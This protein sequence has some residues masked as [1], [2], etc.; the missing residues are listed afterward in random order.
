MSGGADSPESD[1]SDARALERCLA[2]GGV[3]LFGADTVYG[4]ACDPS[5][6]LPVERLYRLKRRS[7]SKPSA[8]MFFDLSLAL[9]ALPELGER[10]RQAMSRLLPG[11]VTLLL[12][13]PEARFPL[14]CGEDLQTLGLRVPRVERLAGVRWPVLQSSANLAGGPDPR[15]LD[16]VPSEIRRAVD[17]VLDDGELPGVSST[18]IDLRRFEV[19]GEWSVIRPGA[20]SEAEVAS[21]LEWQFHFDPD[22]YDA[23][24]R[25][26]IPSY[27]RFQ[28]ELTLATGTGA[29]RIL[30]LGTGTGETA[31][32]L[33]ARHPDAFLVGLDVSGP[34]LA[35]ARGRLPAERVELRTGE[36]QGPLPDG[37]FDVVASALCV[38]H[39]DG[40]E[41][42]DLFARV[43]QVLAPGGRFVL[44]DVVV[45]PD[46]GAMRI[47]LTPGYDRPSSVEDQL[48]WLAGAGFAADV[49]WARG[50][51]A[52]IRAELLG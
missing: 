7:L 41:K 26:D 11:P 17:L 1:G 45:P 38:H 48:H 29:R 32:R 4:L 2:V 9:A 15:R 35:A 37:P 22:T 21:A 23:M 50:D 12:P 51:L 36:I 46:P 3:A 31:G 25:A 43:A 28:E 5:E 27:D 20:V 42:A 16:D 14:A 44:A 8:V 39:L 10:T 18:V 6:R 49:I 30:E 13:N 40:P 19:E 34:M 24:I 52:V 47:S 33:L